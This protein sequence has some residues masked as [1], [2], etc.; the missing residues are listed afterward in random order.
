MINNEFEEQYMFE[1]PTN[2]TTQGVGYY[3]GNIYYSCAE[4]GVPC[5][6]QEIYNNKE[7]LSNLIYKYNLKGELVETLYI[8]NTTLYGEIESCDFEED[9]TLI[10]S[11][12]IDFGEKSTVSLYKSNVIP[13]VLEVSYNSTELT[14]KDVSVTINSN[15]ELQEVSGWTLATDKKSLIKTYSKN[16]QEDIIVKD[17]YG[18]SSIAKINITNIDKE[19]PILDV[20]YSTTKATNQNV[21]VTIKANEEIKNIE[22]WTVVEGKQELTKTYT[23]NETENI[24]IIDLAGNISTTVI[25]IKNIDKQNPVVQVKYSETEQTLNDVIVTIIANEEIQEIEGWN[26]SDDKKMLDKTYTKNEEEIVTIYDLAGNSVVK[27]I[28]VD[29]IDKEK[30]E[31]KVEYSTTLATNKDVIVTITANEEIQEMEG[32]VLSKEKRI[33]TKVYTENTKEEITIKDSAGNVTAQTI[34]KIENIDKV[35]PTI[36]ISYSVT[37]KTDQDI[38]V[39]ISANEE[40]QEVEGW[41]LSDD[42]K[43]LNKTYNKNDEETVTIYDLAGNSIVKTINV[44]NIDKEKPQYKVEYSTTLITNKEVTVTITAN[45]EIQE[46]EGWALSKDKRILTKVYMENTEEEIT[47]KDC[48][49]NITG[50]TI[51]KIENIDKIKP[52]INKSYSITEKTNQDVIITITAN[53]EI[54]EIEGWSLSKDKKVLTKKLTSNIEEDIIVSDLAGNTISDTIKIDNIDRTAPKIEVIYSASSITDKDVLV[55]IKSDKI[56]KKVEGWTLSSDMKQLTKIFEENGKEEVIIIDEAGNEVTTT[57][58]VQNINKNINQDKDE[59]EEKE[60][61]DTIVDMIIP[62]A[63]AKS[64]LG[65][66]IISVVIFTIVRRKLKKYKEIK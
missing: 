55:T 44:E 15:K 1:V 3:K 50:K 27:T 57:V 4:L 53:E 16:I 8:P 26:L 49:G 6:Y 52:I 46:I 65:F 60:K 20:N 30:P 54:K 10:A 63:G 23:E 61:D 62:N 38:I 45:E 35:K 33:L 7:R 19:K 56:I 43:S 2:L 34:I 41:N 32:W 29:N 37:E 13:P 36:N 5:Q 9:G 51:I 48:V 47:I 66:I 25:E 42:K 39:T 21:V 31:Y 22:G 17:L 12:N 58:N 18:N 40:I 24:E 11:Y 28:K 64:I 14:N 59:K